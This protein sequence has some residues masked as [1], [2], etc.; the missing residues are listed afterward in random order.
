MKLSERDI[1][2]VEA[3]VT[4]ATTPDGLEMRL[5]ILASLRRLQAIEEASLPEEPDAISEIR[6]GYPTYTEDDCQ[7]IAAYIDAL[8]AQFA[9]LLVKSKDDARDAERYRWLRNV[10][11]HTH[12][13]HNRIPGLTPSQKLH[14][15]IY[16]DPRSFE[17]I[18]CE[19]PL[20]HVRDGGEPIWCN[21]DGDAPDAEP[22]HFDFA[23]NMDAAIDSAIA[24]KEGKV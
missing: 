1:K 9:A 8:R 3:W 19:I 2:E 16:G 22:G 15:A 5:R 11:K 14:I 23:A 17:C 7:N 21:E 18:T 4:F 20:A 13:G 24:A 6:D 10:N 12:Y